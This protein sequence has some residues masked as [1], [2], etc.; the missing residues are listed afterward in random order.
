MKI[1]FAPMEGVTKY[2][3]RN[4]YEKFY[5]GMDK[6]FAPFISPADNCPLT[7]KEHRDVAKEN[8]VA[9]NLVPQILACKSQYFNEAAGKLKELGYNEINLNLGCPSG[10]VCAK[11]KGSGFLTETHKLDNFLCDIYEY[12]DKENLK[13]SVKTRVGRYEDDEW[14]GLLEIYNKYPI[15][16][17]IV[18]ARVGQDM[19]RGTPRMEQFEYAL[20]RSKNPV[21]YNG[22]AFTPQKIKELEEKYGIDKIML[23]RGLLYNP[24]LPAMYKDADRKFDYD[25][26][27]AFHDE[28]YH[29]YQKIMSPD[30]NVLFHMKALWVYWEKL[31][32]GKEKEVKKILKTKHYSEYECSVDKLF[33]M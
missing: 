11:G 30:K 22:D 20:Q 31:F 1:Y 5:G 8:N 33:R 29:Q 10:T 32:E 23:G 26:F 18:H 6:Y 28:I 16:E 27:R 15:H 12:A 13:I 9:D 7:P 19:Y 14:V 25:N 4:A 24:E 3:F 21:V 17:L 2:I